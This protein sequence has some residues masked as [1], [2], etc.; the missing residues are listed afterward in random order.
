MSKDT[1]QYGNWVSTKLIYGPAVLGAL[2]LGLTFLHVAFVTGAV[3]FIAALAY[4]AYARHAFSSRGGGIQ[5]KL[6]NLVL[7]RLD[8][9]G[10]GQ[11]LDIGCG[12]GAL[13][14]ALAQRHPAAHV[15]GIDTWVK[16][17]DYSKAVCEHNAEAAGVAERTA[18]QRAS[19]SALPFADGCFDA[20]ASNFV[21]HSVSATTDKRALI[22]EALRVVKKGGRFALHDYFT[23]KALYGELDDLLETIKGWGIAEVSFV[24]TSTSDFI[25]RALRLP[26]MLG[27]ISMLYGTK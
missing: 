7:D 21:F 8:W 26:F 1:L 10:T 15:I 13:V 12:N 6:W 14:I 23:V 2:F 4:F 24:N 25:P 11:A 19:A 22:R 9:K 18:F 3:P 20:A 5:T 16:T 27:K 17:W